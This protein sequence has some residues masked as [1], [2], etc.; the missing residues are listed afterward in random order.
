MAG[1]NRV[2][3]RPAS[4]SVSC[5]YDL[6]ALP[7]LACMRKPTGWAN[8]CRMHYDFEAEREGELFC[9]A[10]GLKSTADKRA[11]VAKKMGTF[12]K[13]KVAA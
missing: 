11:W 4:D 6:C 1:R 8:V 12:W 7:A 5:A 13:Q 10:Q 9:D 3:Q 2:L